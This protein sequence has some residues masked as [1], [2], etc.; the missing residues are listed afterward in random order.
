MRE[1]KI[2]KKYHHFKGGEYFVLC[3][4]I[5][6]DRKEFLKRVKMMYFECMHTETY[7]NI[8]IFKSLDECSK[9]L[10]KT[11]NEIVDMLKYKNTKVGRHE[12]RYSLRNI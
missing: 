1:L 3:K 4:S 10:G 9:H 8:K 5:P 11:K 2:F 6:L 12:I 7:N